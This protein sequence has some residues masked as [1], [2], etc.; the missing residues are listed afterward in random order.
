VVELYNIM[1]PHVSPALRP[2]MFSGFS[3]KNV[4]DIHCI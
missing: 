4:N 1:T 2:G 3:G